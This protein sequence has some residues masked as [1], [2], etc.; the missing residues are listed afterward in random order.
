LNI[1]GELFFAE[2]QVLYEL[3]LKNFFTDAEV[4]GEN[5]MIVGLALMKDTAN[6]MYTSEWD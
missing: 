1:K 6:Q 2:S 4:S 3:Y 5:A